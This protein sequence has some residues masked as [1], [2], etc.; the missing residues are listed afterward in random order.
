VIVLFFYVV[1]VNVW[2]QD[3]AGHGEGQGQQKDRYPHGRQ[4][5]LLPY[6]HRQFF[7][8]DP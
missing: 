6:I 4:K 7:P 1:L 8:N 3:N 5:N 2:L